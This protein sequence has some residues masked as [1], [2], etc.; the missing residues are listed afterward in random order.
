MNPELNP[1]YEQTELV[2]EIARKMYDIYPLKD[3]LRPEQARELEVNI[4]KQ[5][6]KGLIRICAR[7]GG[8]FTELQR[9]S[10]KNN[11]PLDPSSQFIID[12][13]GL[14]N[15][16]SKQLN[17]DIEFTLSPVLESQSVT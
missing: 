16:L 8:S 10:I 14:L 9:K 17:M 6:L 5:G 7:M 13:Y 15:Q 4:N 12:Q 3:L 11:T 2:R 1:Y